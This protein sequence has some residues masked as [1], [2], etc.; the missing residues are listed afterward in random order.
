MSG[1]SKR[2][3]GGPTDSGKDIKIFVAVYLNMAK[4]A[5]EIS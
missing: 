3:A 4:V 5:N 1:T 2:W